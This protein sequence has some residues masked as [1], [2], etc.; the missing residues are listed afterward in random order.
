MTIK[1]EARV[2]SAIIEKLA[3]EKKISVFEAILLHCEQSGLE[4]ELAAKLITDGLKTKIKSEAEMLHLINK[5]AEKKKPKK[6][7]IKD[8]R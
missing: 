3:K 5:S 2:F 1:E 4:L 6:K 8:E 7:R